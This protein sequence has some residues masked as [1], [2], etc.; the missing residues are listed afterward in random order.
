M[1]T[2]LNLLLALA[3]SLPLAGTKAQ[4][5]VTFTTSTFAVGDENSGPD[6]LATADVNGDGRLDLISANYGFRWANPGE[7]GGWKNALTVLTNNGSGGFGSNATLTVGFGP[8]AVVAA[9]VNGDGKPDL[10]SAN[11]TDN[12]VTVL[13]NNGSG[14]FGSSATV[15]VGIRPRGLVATDVNGDGALDLV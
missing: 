15:A 7:P 2:K 9:D 4:S 12:T 11:E 6:C 14:L 10:I 5:S 13:T 1:K 3:F 8:S